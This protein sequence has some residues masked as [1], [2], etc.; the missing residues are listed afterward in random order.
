MPPG[1]DPP[2]FWIW[3]PDGLRI[4]FPGHPIFINWHTAIL[5][6]FIFDGLSEVC[7]WLAWA[8]RVVA[9]LAL[10]GLDLGRAVRASV[11]LSRRGGHL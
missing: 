5:Y 10:A 1:R 7:D 11:D 9:V 6:S 8:L 3:W 4:P 2:H